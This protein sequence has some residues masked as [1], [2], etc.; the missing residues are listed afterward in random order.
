MVALDVQGIGSFPITL[1]AANAPKAV[2]ILQSFAASSNAVEIHRAEPLP[3]GADL[4]LTPRGD[5]T[6]PVVTPRSTHRCF[7]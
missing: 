2:A 3:A 7:V 1:D 5:E 4:A 6:P